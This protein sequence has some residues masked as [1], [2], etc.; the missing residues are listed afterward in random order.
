[1]ETGVYEIVNTTTGK[2]YIGSATTFRGRFAVHRHELRRGVHHSEKLQRSWDK[3][4]ED[5]FEFRKVLVCEPRHLLMYE[6]IAIDALNPEYNIL[7]IA[8]SVLGHRW[9]EAARARIRGR[10]ATFAG[11]KHSP[12]TIERM[13]AARRGKPSPTKGKARDPKAVEAT[14][15]AHRGK[16]RSPETC[17]KISAK[18]L[19]R[20]M[21]QGRHE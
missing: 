20:R 6:Q 10:K 1:M 13:A 8:G 9:S 17:A 4:G 21:K 7:R 15:A 16:K 18:A 12:E 11:R 3:H 14:A 19:G 5:A 2:R